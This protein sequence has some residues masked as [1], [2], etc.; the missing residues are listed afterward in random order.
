[1]LRFKARTH[2][3]SRVAFCRGEISA[4]TAMIVWSGVMAGKQVP[5]GPVLFLFSVSNESKFISAAVS[6][7]HV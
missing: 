6:L 3:A 4:S 5:T 7:R 2:I 1:M